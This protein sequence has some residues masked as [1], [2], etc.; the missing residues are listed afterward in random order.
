MYVTKDVE[1]W[2]HIKCVLPRSIVVPL[3]ILHY[4]GRCPMWFYNILTVV[5]SIIVAICSTVFIIPFVRIGNKVMKGYFV[6]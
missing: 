4:K 1:A 2:R 6:A 3:D 5:V